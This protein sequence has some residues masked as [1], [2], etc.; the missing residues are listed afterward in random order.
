[1]STL[2]SGRNSTPSASRR[3]PLHAL[4][5]RKADSRLCELPVRED[6]AV[7]GDFSGLRVAVEAEAD[8]ACAAGIARERRHAPIA[9]N[10]AARMLRTAAY[11]VF[12]RNPSLIYVLLYRARAG[13]LLKAVRSG[14][15]EGRG[16]LDAVVPREVGVLLGVGGFS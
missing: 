8:A 9:H 15:D 12:G 13:V 11:T 1:M 4:A 3:A 16:L 2:P 7:A 6:D 10:A 14:D 5:G